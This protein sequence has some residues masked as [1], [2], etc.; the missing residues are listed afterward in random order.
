MTTNP[1]DSLAI[2][3]HGVGSSGSDLAPL[4]AALQRF[5]PA[6][7]FVSPDAPEPSSLGTGF[8]WYDGIG[9]NDATRV[10]R[11][12]AARTG[13]DRVVNQAIEANNFGG[14]PERVALVGF[15]QGAILALDALA[16]GRWALAAIVA[17]AGRLASQPPYAPPI[18][19][20]ALLVHG[21]AD[22]VIPA[23]EMRTAARLLTEAGVVVETELM[24]AF[25]H[26]IAPASIPLAGQYLARRLV[27]SF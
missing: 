1:P 14:R 26:T 24:P 25:G 5:L 20:H 17:F 4:G 9:L 12:I 11:I 3:L 21:D 15:S 13:F 6:T 8:Q 2:L 7:R 22:P 23:T 18:N 10:E 19:A 27:A 16:T